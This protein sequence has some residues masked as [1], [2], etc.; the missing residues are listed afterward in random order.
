MLNIFNKMQGLKRLQSDLEN[1]RVTI[2]HNGVHIT[3]N[4]KMEIVDL[5]FDAEIEPDPETLK[6][7]CNEAIRATQKRSAQM[8]SELR[9]Q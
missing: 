7:A 9:E 3:M 4:G 5:T 2:D 8:I 1:E 6:R